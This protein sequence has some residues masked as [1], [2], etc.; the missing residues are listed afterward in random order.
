[1]LLGRRLLAPLQV[2]GATSDD[3][4]LRKIQ[5]NDR[6]FC[7]TMESIPP[8]YY[9]PTDEEENWLK[10]QPKGSKKYH[11]DVL[12]QNFQES[13][14]KSFKRAKF[15]P[16]E[17]KTNEERQ[18]ETAEDE[19][20]QKKKQVQKTRVMKADKNP[21]ATSLDGLKERLALKIQAHRE[22]R[23][24]DEKTGKKR[25]ENG[26]AKI[27]PAQKKRK[28]GTA[29][30]GSAFNNKTG[31]KDAE[32]ATEAKPKAT[33]AAAASVDVSVDSISYGSLLLVDEKKP[34]EKKTRNGQGIRGIKNLLKKAERNQQRMDELKK[35]EEGKAVVEAKQWNSAIKQAAGELVMD[36]PK[37]L[38][39]KL[40]KKEKAKAKSTKE[41]KQR[42]AHVEIS[43]KEKQKKR[44]ANISGG[45]HAA[46]NEKKEKETKGRKGP[47]AGFEGKKGESFLNAE[48][49]K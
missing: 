31:K 29:S 18:L 11:R 41:W 33:S 27:E 32:D 3:A 24:A 36:D 5:L 12:A 4:A 2:A 25:K 14:K 21:S 30:L 26:A 43:K 16:S 13:S 49:K 9:F 15:S 40:K 17:Q 42:V 35:T 8:Q 22:Q 38:R 23:K 20:R 45:R 28:T 37:L 10:S 46:L 6:F 44:L 19:K 48:K 34:V 47:R 1:M 7:E 39:N